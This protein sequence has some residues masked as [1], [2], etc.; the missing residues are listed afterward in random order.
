V[1]WIAVPSD[2]GTEW[3]S[4]GGNAAACPLGAAAVGSMAMRL[5]LRERPEIKG[6][7]RPVRQPSDRG[8]EKPTPAAASS[9]HCACKPPWTG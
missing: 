3:I 2:V 6:A 9:M 4:G 5:Y 8:G 7:D 1:S